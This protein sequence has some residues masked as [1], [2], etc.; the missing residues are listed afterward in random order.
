MNFLKYLRAP[1]QL[2]NGKV[3]D[4]TF[5]AAQTQST[6]R[7][8]QTSKSFYQKNLDRRLSTP[9]EYEDPYKQMR[10]TFATSMRSSSRM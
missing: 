6:W 1:M 5:T 2:T 10:S 8:R 4:D 9:R 7:Q 3:K